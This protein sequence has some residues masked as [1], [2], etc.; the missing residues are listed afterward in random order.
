MGSD[1]LLGQKGYK[2]RTASW[3]KHML[4]GL[5]FCPFDVVGGLFG[6]EGG[7]AVLTSCVCRLL[8]RKLHGEMTCQKGRRAEAVEAIALLSGCIFKVCAA[9]AEPTATRRF[10]IWV[11]LHEA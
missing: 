3:V 1:F 8:A 10:S 4:T 7:A 9:F 5:G 2:V 6:V 11:A